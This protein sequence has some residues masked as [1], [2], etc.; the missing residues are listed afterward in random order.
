VVLTRDSRSSN[1]VIPLDWRVAKR[2]TYGDS[3][4]TL[5]RDLPG[6]TEV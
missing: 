4:I 3:V 6:T 5:I 1:D 2:L